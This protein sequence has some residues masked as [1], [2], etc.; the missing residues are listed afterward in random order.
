MISV[1]QGVNT[2]KTNAGVGRKTT[3]HGE[4]EPTHRR[5]NPIGIE[6]VESQPLGAACRGQAIARGSGGRTR[7]QA[8]AAPARSAVA[9]TALRPPGALSL[10]RGL[11]LPRRC[12][13][14]SSDAAAGAH[15]P[16]DFRPLHLD[17][18]HGGASRSPPRSE[19]QRQ[20]EWTRGPAH[21]GQVEGPWRDAAHSG[22]FAPA[23]SDHRGSGVELESLAPRECRQ[24][25]H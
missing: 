12:H 23:Q 20:S 16:R 25:G 15:L 19:R 13:V 5:K 18:P 24:P 6:E 3:P 4:P 22:F 7:A 1:T 10:A 11:A 2:S 14:C 9:G 21:R 17:L 8:P